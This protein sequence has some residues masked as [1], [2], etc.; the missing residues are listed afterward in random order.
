MR[1]L[2]LVILTIP[3]V[4]GCSQ[5]QASPGRTK[6]AS[7]WSGLR[8]DL[9]AEEAS[10]LVAAIKGLGDRPF[11]EKAYGLILQRDPETAYAYGIS[12]PYG[13]PE[14]ALTDVS[15]EHNLGTRQLYLGLRAEADR[16]LPSATGSDAL[17]LAALSR[18]LGD[19]SRDIEY[20][21]AKYPVSPYV[22]S[23]D[24]LTIDYFTEYRQLRDAAEAERYITCLALLPAKIDGIVKALDLRAGAG[25][26]LP[27]GIYE[28]TLQG[29]NE[30]ASAPALS[31]PFYTAFAR[32][33]AASSVPEGAA[34]TALLDKA[35]KAVERS[36][37]PAWKSLA[38]AL[39][40]QAA[41]V[42]AAG[43]AS[44][45]PGGSEYYAACLSRLT[46]TSMSAAE[47]NEL[48][49]RELSR[50]QSEIRDG[51]AALGYPR[52]LSLAELYDRL[53]RDG[54]ALS[55]RDLL[56]RI[57]ADMKAMDA[58]LGEL[59]LMRP[60]L[61]VEAVQGEMG[62]YYQPPSLDGR[63]GRYFV[64][65]SDQRYVYDI[66]TTVYHETL[67]GHHL[68]IARALEADLPGFLR[69]ADF[70]GYTEGWALY[71]ERLA[72]EMGC[73]RD[74]PAGNLGRLRMEALRA[75]RLVAD[76]GV[77]AMGWSFGQAVDFLSRNTGLGQ[78]MIQADVTRYII[79]PGQATAYYTGYAG[80]LKLR[81]RCRTELG[82]KFDLRRFN[83]AI[84]A[85]GALPLDLV[86]KVVDGFI[87]AEKAR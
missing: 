58:R 60:R 68:Q 81:E 77:N 55:G 87:A 30:V 69:G 63:P 71:A 16:R 64:A 44:R 35:A 42:P 50:I 20:S 26:V 65:D 53:G 11:L 24:Q 34:R 74:D 51:F 82:P 15:D 25:V 45:L 2:A 79:D 12:K 32:K 43:G 72:F 61:G 14:D 18:W 3:L 9:S 54:G 28:Y 46:T 1:A 21:L 41:S 70:L 7:T 38:E 4:A 86:G 39:G 8:P 76:T 49:K 48:G 27:R 85:N 80:I 6:A 23:V 29:V 37:I 13:V 31:S 22:N 17:A 52:D 40:R 59:V 75:A 5:S 78:G 84:L 36:A 56:F 67:P 10:G 57:D 47:I 19:K 83:E 66:A 73:Y 33:L 62:G